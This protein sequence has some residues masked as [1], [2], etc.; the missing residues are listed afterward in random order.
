LL[1]L[2]LA[3]MAHSLALLPRGY[4]NLEYLL[5]GA[6]SVF[7]PRSVV[8]VMLFLESLADIACAISQTYMLSVKDMFESLR[9]LHSLPTSR[10]IEIVAAFALLTVFCAAAAHVLHRTEDRLWVA[11]SFMLL[12][13]IVISTAL[14]MG[15]NPFK[16]ADVM[17]SHKRLARSPVLSLV[18]SESFFHNVDLAAHSTDGGGM[19]SASSHAMDFLNRPYAVKSPDV[20]LIVVESWGLPLDAHIARALNAPYD[21]PRVARKYGVSFGAVPF[22]GSTVPGEARE[23]CQSR[24]GFDLLIASPESLRGCLPALFHARNYE[25]LAIHGYYGSMFQR[26]IWYP[27]IGF[28]QVWFRAD[29]DK[30]KLPECDGA[31]PGICDAAIAGWIG[32]SLLSVDTGKPRFIYWVTLNSHLP[33]PAHPNL[34][35]D[36]VCSTL[37]LLRDSVPLC[38]WFRLVR[39]VHHSVQ[40]L[41]LSPS[42]RPTVFVVV[43]DH[44]PP[45]ADSKQRQNFSATDVPYVLLTP[46]IAASR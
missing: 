25:N 1:S 30:M 23:L 33:V 2:P 29:L 11:G 16:R 4:I 7:L 34:T 37:P 38:S 17:Y 5:I 19:N 28:D 31:F 39:N 20:V 43:G 6:F 26:E 12:I 15:Q 44:A 14:L 3:F 21:D 13:A 27:K 22:G 41:A 32:S 36:G 8:L 40:Q 42:A 9:S 10:I 24:M 35:D 45:F 46:R 18:R